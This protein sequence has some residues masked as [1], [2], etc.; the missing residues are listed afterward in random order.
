MSIGVRE[1]SEED[2][3]HYFY[4]WL[5]EYGGSHDVM[6]LQQYIDDYDSEIPIEIYDKDLCPCVLCIGEFDYD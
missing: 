3:N 6:S 1:I 2:Y 4:K 5:Y